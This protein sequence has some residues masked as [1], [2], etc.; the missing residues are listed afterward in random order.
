MAIV[1]DLPPEVLDL[2]LA[3]LPLR[4]AARSSVLSVAWGQSWRQLSDLDFT[5]STC[6]R[7]AIDAVLLG[8]SGSVRRV[9]LEVTDDLLPRV[10][11]W[12]DALSEKML[13]SLNLNFNA[14]SVPSVLM[15]GQVPK[16]MLAC[17]ALK[18]LALNRC[19]LPA[20][21]ASFTGF[22]P[23]LT[24]LCLTCSSFDKG[25]DLEAMIAMP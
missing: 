17:G 9:R 13:Q 8:H 3:R 25:S 1:S 15:E 6:D 23:S 22:L 18:D 5:S 11:A 4:D 16:S 14:P 20:I 7:S 10:Q 19:V 12:V 2:I 21:P 24:K